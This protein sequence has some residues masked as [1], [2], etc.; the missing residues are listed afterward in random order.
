[1]I[2]RLGLLQPL[3]WAILSVVSCYCGQPQPDPIPQAKAKQSPLELRIPPEEGHFDVES[4]VSHEPIFDLAY[5]GQAKDRLSRIAV[6]TESEEVRLGSVMDEL[7]RPA[8]TF[9]LL[10]DK[11]A[12]VR[13]IIPTLMYRTRNSVILPPEVLL[14][15]IVKSRQHYWVRTA[16]LSALYSLRL[17]MTT[18]GESGVFTMLVTIGDDTPWGCQLRR[19]PEDEEVGLVKFLMFSDDSL[20]LS[21][22][23]SCLFRNGLIRNWESLREPVTRFFCGENDRRF[24]ESAAMYLARFKDVRSEEFLCAALRTISTAETRRLEIGLV[25]LEENGSFGLPSKLMLEDLDSRLRSNG[26][27]AGKD[28]FVGLRRMVN[29]I[30]EKVTT[31]R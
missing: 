29:R 19:L 24:S 17:R 8:E 18:K 31:G 12:F 3:N 13:Y 15:R 27:P 5:L 11:V 2:P 28:E 7:G 22:A 26:D 4:W 1:M 25:A 23:L 30:R 16:A 9:E 21:D 20:Q 14:A 10:V 6:W